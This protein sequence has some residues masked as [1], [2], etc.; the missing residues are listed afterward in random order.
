MTSFS[1]PAARN[2]RVLH[3]TCPSERRGGRECRAFGAPA[4]LR[5]TKKSTQASH[6]RYAETVRHSLRNGLRLIARSPRCPGFDSHR[7]PAKRLAELDPS[8]GGSGPHAFAVR[9]RHARPA[10]H[11]RPSHPAP[12]MVTIGRNVPLHRGGMREKI[13]VICPT[14]QAPTHAAD[15]HDGQSAH[16]GMRQSP[17]PTGVSNGPIADPRIRD[18]PFAP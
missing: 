8:V 15:W 7:H 14:P 5:A 10:C 9:A 3:R 1:I 18:Q 16:G 12:R 2:A 13:V 11:P 17:S 6:H 4:A